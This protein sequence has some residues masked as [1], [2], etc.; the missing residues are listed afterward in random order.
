MATRIRLSVDAPSNMERLI[1]SEAKATLEDQIKAAG[2]DFSEAVS[3]AYKIGQNALDTMTPKSSFPS[4]ANPPARMLTGAMRAAFRRKDPRRSQKD[5]RFEAT[6]GW[7][8]DNFKDYYGYQEEGFFHAT[9]MRFIRGVNALEHAEQAFIQDM[10]RR[11]Y[12][13]EEEG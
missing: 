8:D 3:A 5:A 11:G 13:V 9:A 2:R 10:N 12:N 7:H 4:A 1:T 6:L